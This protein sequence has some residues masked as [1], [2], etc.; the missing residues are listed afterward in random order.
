VNSPADGP[1]HGASGSERR[2]ERTPPTPGG[3]EAQIHQHL[4][5]MRL[6]A[7]S[8]MAGVVVFG[9]VALTLLASGDFEPPGTALPDL[10]VGGLAVASVL[11]IVA[12]PVVTRKLAERRA[13]DLAAAL[14]R[15]RTRVVIGFALREAAGALGIL[16]AL[17]TGFTSWGLALAG[18]AL[19]TMGVAWPR[20][21]DLDPGD[22][23]GAGDRTG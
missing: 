5:A 18:A 19:V 16:L 23:A 8:M 12:A 3:A 2:A 6:L 14:Q 7:G 21:E 1:P 11:L 4:K 9:A 17:L 22:D 15:H 13:Q 20:R 10:L